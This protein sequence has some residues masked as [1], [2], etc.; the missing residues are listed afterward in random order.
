[1]RLLKILSTILNLYLS[2]TTSMFHKRSMMLSSLRFAIEIEKLKE[3]VNQTIEKNVELNQKVSE[4]T[5]QEIIND[6]SSDLAALKKRNLTNWQK[7]LN[8]KTL[9][10]LENVETLKNSYYPTK[11]AS[12]TESNEVTVTM[13]FRFI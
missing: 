8:I 7:V 9:R 1:M 3:E 10:V 4:N 5:R 12:D 2:L 13:L 11:E 6:V